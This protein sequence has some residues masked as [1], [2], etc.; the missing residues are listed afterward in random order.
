MPLPGGAMAS[1]RELDRTLKAV[2]GVVPNRTPVAPVNPD[3]F[4]E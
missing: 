2:A 1:M 3:P 4:R